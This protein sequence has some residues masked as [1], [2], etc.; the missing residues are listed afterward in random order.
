[1]ISSIRIERFKS[2]LDQDF[3]LG[4]LTV[5]TG[6]NGAGKSTVLQAI[7]LMRQAAARP[8]G[9]YVELN[10][11]YSL[12]LGEAVEVL[13]V[14]AERRD[15]IKLSLK[16]E[17]GQTCD[18]EFSVSSERSQR[19]KKICKIPPTHSSSING[20]DRQFSYLCAERIGPRD[21]F[22]AAS[23]DENDL[24]VG[25][26]GEAVAQVLATQDKSEV[27]SYLINS[28]S[29]AVNAR[30]N[31]RDQTELWLS[32]IV[33]PIQIDAQ[34]V[35]GTNVTTLRFK[36]PGFLS[37]W[38]RPS[39][40]GFGLTYALPVIVSGLVLKPG[41]ILLVENPEAHLH[42]KGQSAIG[43]FLARVSRSGVQVIVETH[44]DHVLNGIRKAVAIDR[45][46][47]AEQIL[48]YFFDIG[49]SKEGSYSQPKIQKIQMREN[50][51]IF[52]WPSKFFDQIESDLAQLA[53][54]RTKKI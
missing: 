23:F 9:D 45:V 50:G 51:E 30:S 15:G 48:I 10:G 5:L 7:L 2:Y 1:M 8:S 41:S 53:L 19:L 32:S 28:Q 47:P 6:T 35:A 26:R 37:D 13:H 54:V 44:S 49:T 20:T 36:H 46:I 12:A 25:A 31:L 43:E 4:N 21:V 16:D 40:A 38:V 39:N 3:S 22:E 14:S 18:F 27:H 52:P 33:R 42:P 24:N 11:P 17:L 29:I 34:W